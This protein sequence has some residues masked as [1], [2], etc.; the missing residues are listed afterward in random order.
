MRIMSRPSPILRKFE[1]VKGLMGKDGAAQP[2]ARIRHF[3]GGKESASRRF[4]VLSTTRG[5]KV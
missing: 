4:A 3:A 5:L 1:D 2:G